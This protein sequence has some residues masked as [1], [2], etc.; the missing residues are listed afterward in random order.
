MAEA[1]NDQSG[2]NP[3]KAASGR[4]TC[5]A[6]KMVLDEAIKGV[7]GVKEN[8]T[9]LGLVRSAKDQTQQAE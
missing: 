3:K 8:P 5:D 4:P 1:A 7:K 9:A 2:D 6:I